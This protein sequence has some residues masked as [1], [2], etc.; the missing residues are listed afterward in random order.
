MNH[1]ISVRSTYMYLNYYNIA[2]KYLNDCV[3]PLNKDSELIF[4]IFDLESAYN[5]YNNSSI[6]LV[7]DEINVFYGYIHL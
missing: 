7:S 3:Y 5:I 2:C 6:V 1:N 4:K